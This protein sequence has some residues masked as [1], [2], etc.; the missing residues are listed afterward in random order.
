MIF[1][2]SIFNYLKIYNGKAI[3]IGKI[4]VLNEYYYLHS[5]GKG[6][7]VGIPYT[8]DYIVELWGSIRPYTK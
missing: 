6:W 4:I 2:A 5:H 8:F 1:V 7:F 3:I